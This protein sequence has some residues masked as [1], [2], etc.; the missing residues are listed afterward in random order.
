MSAVDTSVASWKELL[1]GNNALRSIALAGGVSMQAIN[2]YMVTTILPTVIQDIGGLAYYAWSTTL[3]VVASIVGSALAAKLIEALGPRHS[4]LMALAVFSAGS[5]VCALASSMPVLLAGRSVQGFGGGILIAL[6]YAL[7]RVVFEERLWPRA[8]ALISG[9]W[10][11]ATLSGPA[12]GGVFAESGHW[13]WAFW[14]LLPI[15]LLLALIVIGQFEARTRNNSTSTRLPL[16]TIGL[17][18]T[19]VM[20]I[21]LASLSREWLWSLIGVASGL[22][23]GALIAWRDNRA[24][25][26]LLPTG[27]YSLT[28]PLGRLYAIMT[29]LIVAI[30]CEIFV[31]YFLQLIHGLSPLSAGYLTAAMAGGWT[32]GSL[33][34]AGKTGSGVERLSRLGPP[35][36]CLA[37]SALAVMT[38]LESLFE[39]TLGAGLYILALAAVGLGIGLGWPH[40]LTRV[41]IAAEPGEETLASSSITTVQLYASALAAA[42]AGVIVNGAGLLEPGGVVGAQQAAVWLFGV[43]GVAPLLAMLLMA[44]K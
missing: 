14:F 27:A 10:G 8:M 19:S 12:I 26:K 20:A 21:S 23:L 39:T 40:L 33:F 35:L 6:S 43:S 37:L 5:M 31:P 3:F 18:V 44:R 17:L 38:P 24:L 28:K 1:E 42:L 4:Y 11:L 29:L 15:A 7:I 41:F 9:M 25:V 2:V 34:S 30:T 32:I 13:R 36:V 22:G 16:A